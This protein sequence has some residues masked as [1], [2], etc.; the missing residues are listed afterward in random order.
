MTNKQR[1]RKGMDAGVAE[2]MWEGR[3]GVGEEGYEKNVEWEG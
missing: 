3:K 1:L 2:G